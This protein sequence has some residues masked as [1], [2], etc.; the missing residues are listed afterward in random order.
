MGDGARTA[1]FGLFEPLGGYHASQDFEPKPPGGSILPMEGCRLEARMDEKAGMLARLFERSMGLGREWEVTDVWF[2]ERGGA[3]DELHVR[4]AHA[5]GEAVECPVCHRRC[6][7]YDARER[8]WRHLDIWQY[9]TIVHCAVP[10][11]DCPEDGVHTVRMPWEV[12]P[13]SHFTA[14]FEAE[15]L[16]MAMS[17]M[18][19]T[20]IAK[21]VR[22]SDRRVWAMLGR[23]ARE[24]REAADYSGVT[25]AGIDDTACRR[26]QSYISTMVDLDGA[27]VVAVCEGRDKGAPARL[28]AQ[29][30][31]HG[32]DRMAI[33][34]VTRDMSEAYALGA[35]EAMP[36]AA[37]T[38]D[39]F[40][41]MQLFCKATDK[42]RCRE[43][44]SCEEKRRLLRRTK[45]VWLKRPE[46]LTE[47]QRA[48]KE[49]LASEHLLCAR[50]CAM[51]EAMRAVYACPDRA[52]A[53][54]ELDRLTSWM[55]HSNVDEM[56]VVA[57]TVR[58]EREGILNW[59][60]RNAT[61][62]IMEGLNSVIQSIKRAARGFR[63][64]SY[65]ETM[66]F[67]RLGRLDFSAQ[68][69]V[70]CATH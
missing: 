56:K 25:R 18:T 15:V 29:L 49:S 39:R 30:E 70:A 45:Y 24:A 23:A 10:R 64:T 53:A 42:V 26:G 44:K 19:V 12:R 57:K 13:N 51:T 16:V 41:V 68:T 22:E 4:V 46:R 2:E 5:R 33:R 58:K 47:W 17:G 54:S 8:T 35:A 20:E 37:Q 63:N 48:R 61:N 62:A 34:E 65:F 3:P 14:L 55:M 52:S 60:S 28:A 1:F 27:R 21:R 69:T 32:G 66:I 38:V 43:A 7:T 59:F 6:G 40:H 11:A 31:E 67:L 50:A 9:E 36:N